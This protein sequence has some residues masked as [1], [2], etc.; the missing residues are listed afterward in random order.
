MRSP[1]FFQKTETGD[2]LITQILLEEE[3]GTVDT[4]YVEREQGLIVFF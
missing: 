2:A 4:S 3:E 1:L